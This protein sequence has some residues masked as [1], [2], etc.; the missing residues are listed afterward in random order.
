MPKRIHYENDCDIRT[1]NTCTGVSI[2]QPSKGFFQKVDLESDTVCSI[3]LYRVD[4]FI[5]ASSHLVASLLYSL[6]NSPNSLTRF[7]RD[8]TLTNHEEAKEVNHSMNQ[9]S[10]IINSTDTQTLTTCERGR[11][12]SDKVS[13]SRQLL[14]CHKE[15]LTLLPQL[16][17]T[18]YAI[19]E[20]VWLLF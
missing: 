20:R 8:M 17:F 7:A 1:V 19:K 6:I 5:I 14:I 18:P 2:F 11:N 9:L 15:K 10:Q 12:C 3:N 13:N 4:M 16:F